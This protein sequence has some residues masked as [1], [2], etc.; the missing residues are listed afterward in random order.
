MKIDPKTLRL[1]LTVIEE[2]TITA[3]AEREH[4]APAAI[5]KRIMDLEGV[6]G[7]QLLSRTNKGITPT[8]AGHALVDMAQRILSDLDGVMLLMRDYASGVTGQV[9]IAANISAI[10]QFLPDGLRG[11]MDSNPLV[12]V[13]V[14][15][16][17]ST[18]VAQAVATNVADIGVLASGI[19]TIDLEYHNYR[20]DELVV[21]A[22]PSHPVASYS[23]V[24]FATVLDYDFV[25]LHTGSQPNSLLLRAA[26]ELGR[27]WRCRVQVTSF[28]A[29]CRMVQAGLGIGVLPR[30]VAEFFVK[31]LG[32]VMCRL[33]EPW[34][35][36]QLLLAVRSYKELDPAARL[37]VDHL[38]ADADVV[39]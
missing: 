32:L 14:E 12:Q 30:R 1:F 29:Q 13:S 8:P 3:A 22:P 21:I 7:V 25:G 9:H 18:G 6:L 11:F 15:E 37:L 34:A 24:R 2:G 5:S 19:A 17:I 28:D 36:R 35:H 4:I 27:S 20:R 16:R 39:T 10:T 38:L 23:R 33:D 31:G 26:A